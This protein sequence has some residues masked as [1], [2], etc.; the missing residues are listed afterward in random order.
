MIARSLSNILRAALVFACLWQRPAVTRAQSLDG[1]NAPK[2][3]LPKE[4]EAP[5]VAV[6]KL[7]KEA[8]APELPMPGDVSAPEDPGPDDDPVNQSEPEPPTRYTDKRPRE[9]WSAAD[10]DQAVRANREDSTEFTVEQIV[11]P[12]IV[13]ASNKAES[14]RSAPA[15]V[16]TI[17]RQDLIDRGYSEL[18]QVLDDLPSMDIVRPYGDTYFKNYWRGYRNNVGSAFLLMIDGVVFNSLWMNETW[19]LTALPLSNVDH[20]EVLYGPASSTYGANAAMGVVNIITVK[21]VAT[22]GAHLR[23]QVI[24]STPTKVKFKNMT[25]SADAQ[26]LY[27]GPGFRLSASAHLESG[28]LDPGAGD[29]FEY[30]QNHYYKDSS[31]WSTASNY[32][33]LSEGFRSRHEKIG[34]D[35]RLFVGNHPACSSASLVNPANTALGRCTEIAVQHFQLT[36]GNGTEYAAD[37]FQTS[38]Q[39][40]TVEQ[41]AYIRH[42]QDITSNLTSQTLL[43]FRNSNID[44]PSFVY[45]RRDDGTVTAS[46][47]GSNNRSWAAAQDFTISA[48]RRLLFDD[49]QLGFSVG[50][51]YERLDLE[52]AYLMSQ[53]TLPNI[54][55]SGLVYPGGTPDGFPIPPD[56]SAHV[57]NRAHL[58]TA[59]IYALARYEFLSAHLL[60]IGFR[61]DYNEAWRSD[62]VFRAGY[63]GRF[64]RDFTVKL[65][66]GQAYQT[67]TFR[68][69]YGL[70]GSDSTVTRSSADLKPE[71]SHTVE[72]SL[73][74]TKSIIAARLG[75]YYVAYTD[76]IVSGPAG[77]TNLDQRHVMG[78]DLGL[79]LL[80]PVPFM[81]RL[82]LWAYYSPIL[83]AEQSLPPAVANST[84]GAVLMETVA[85]KRIADVGDLARHKVLVGATGEF[86]KHFLVTFLGRFIG[87]R[88]TVVTNPIDTIPAY[89]SLDANI[90]LRD[91]LAPG[92]AIG[93]RGTN[94]LNSTYFHPGI[95]TADSGDAPGTWADTGMWQGSQGTYNSKLP[96]PGREL[97]LTFRLDL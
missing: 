51:R 47:W 22:D 7:P 85:A 54:G 1:L 89:F 56:G 81:E 82:K 20:I 83:L 70:Q 44:Q 5:K 37:R 29:K 34:V 27:K 80:I 57:Q 68:D 3:E 4:P 45:E 67:P 35:I 21:D 2:V 32:P 63:V 55:P 66:Y 17:T 19:V 62:P 60:H 50:V 59:G 64:G 87:P 11:N 48:G 36:T 92:L 53:L 18:S 30:S 25:K 49:D 78:I 40:T 79:N 23:S 26:V 15:W 61:V 97:Y 58:D 88:D 52:R 74:F 10:Q 41:S 43:R 84:A 12:E 86:N 9:L 77:V 24:V 42:I 31:L 16:I 93:L 76:P 69:M 75:A 6:P 96:Q 38:T 95:R 73:D 14:S 28:V 71:R 65:M 33:G 8:S 13:T 39:W 91:V 46:Y 72:A 94:L 90:V